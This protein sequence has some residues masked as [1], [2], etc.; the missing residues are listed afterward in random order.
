MAVLAFHLHWS[1]DELLRLEHRDRRVWVEQVS[2]INQRI[3]DQAR[4]G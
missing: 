3:N 1:H 4:T 2:A